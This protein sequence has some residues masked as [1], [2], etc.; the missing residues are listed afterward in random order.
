MAE[1]FNKSDSGVCSV[2]DT[3][4]YVI[5]AAVSSGSAMV[6]ALCCIFVIGLIFLFKKQ[7]FFAQRLI[8]YHCLAALFRSL[9][10]I[11]RLHRLGYQHETSALEAVCVISAFTNQVTLW[12]LAVDYLVITFTLLMTAVFHKNVARLEGVFVALIFVLPLTFNWIPFI[13]DSYG[14]FGPWCWIRSLNYSD[15]SEHQFGIVLQ[16]VMWNA[17]FMIILVILLPTYFFTIAYIARH[18]CCLREKKVVNDPELDRLKKH[19]R[20]EIWWP[21]LFFPL[22]VIFLNFF[23]LVRQLYDAANPDNP[24]YPIWL[25]N[26][27]FS[28]LQGGYIALVYVL[29]GGTLKRI[30]YGNIKATLSRRET[31]SEY[32]AESDGV[33]DSVAVDDYLRRAHYRHYGEDC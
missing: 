25:L 32:P 21:L 11:L 24:S 31:V 14:R 7:Q 23:P 13:N 1:N 29:D 5:V 16:Y 8:L 30:T 2:L 12:A 33:T 22:G 4:D 27:I 15:C 28:P 20:N 9:S 18:K 10:T 3:H 6:S 17:P 19:L 26:V